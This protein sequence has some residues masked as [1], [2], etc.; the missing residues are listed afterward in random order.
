ML[1]ATLVIYPMRLSL[2]ITS[3][4]IRFSL[5]YGFDFAV[6]LSS[7]SRMIFLSILESITICSSHKKKISP[8][9]S[10]FGQFQ[11]LTIS[12]SFILLTYKGVLRYPPTNFTL[13]VLDTNL[14]YFSNKSVINLVDEPFYILNHSF[15]ISD[16]VYKLGTEIGYVSNFPC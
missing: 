15:I 16:L 11:S 2:V 6:T 1:V 3:Y 14:P 10:N 9:K 13:I 5:V 12:S 4:S 8:S 7:I